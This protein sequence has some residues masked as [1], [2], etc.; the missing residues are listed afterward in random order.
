MNQ[1]KNMDASYTSDYCV[2]I[3]DPDHLVESVVQ[4]NGYHQRLIM[5][6]VVDNND[7]QKPSDQTFDIDRMINQSLQYQPMISTKTS[8]GFHNHV[9]N[10]IHHR[11]S[12][13]QPNQK[14]SIEK[15]KRLLLLHHTAKCKVIPG[16]EKCTVT[17]HCEQMKHLWIHIQDCT[18]VRCDV[19]HCYSSRWILS[20]FA[21]CIDVKCSCCEPV[22]KV[23]MN[24]QKKRC[25]PSPL[26]VDEMYKLKIQSKL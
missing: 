16:I 14:H 3:V 9:Q 13:I 22:R 5:N 10:T 2:D 21:K 18:V 17:K 15:T 8:N 23:I 6:N 4:D 1:Q 25:Q 20:H 12:R 26:L 19:P 7:K 11:K 24:D